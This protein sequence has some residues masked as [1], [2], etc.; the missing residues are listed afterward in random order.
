[1]MEGSACVDESEASAGEFIE[2]RPVGW[3]GCGGEV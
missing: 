3:E 1:M 2:A